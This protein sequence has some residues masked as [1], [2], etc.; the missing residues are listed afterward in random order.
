MHWA[1]SLTQ[2]HTY[3]SWLVSHT[4]SSHF[5][6]YTHSLS[7][8]P[9]VGADAG[10]AHLVVVEVCE[11]QDRSRLF[12]PFNPLRHRHDL[13]GAVEQVVDLGL[14]QQEGLQHV[15]QHSNQGG[16]IAHQ[17]IAWPH[18]WIAWPGQWIKEERKDRCC[19]VTST[20]GCGD[21]YVSRRMGIVKGSSNRR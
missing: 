8:T 2:S 18:Q 12:N 10:G 1:R 7:H 19:Q 9:H 11:G 20:N 3:K 5:L 21:D 6:L 17:W 16:W 15:L 14:P 13:L 4:L